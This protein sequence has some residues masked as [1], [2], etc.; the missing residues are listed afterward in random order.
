MKKGELKS[1]RGFTVIEVALVL[2]IA[3]L[4]FLMV[5]VALPGLRTSQR[6]TERREDV[7]N[8]LSNLKKYQTNNRG[9]L[10]TKDNGGREEYSYNSS[11]AGT[12]VTWEYFYRD[13]LGE[14]FMDPNGVN[15]TLVVKKCSAMAANRDCENVNLSNSLFPNDYKIY[16]VT[17]AT[18]SGEKAVGTSNPRKVAVLYKLEGAGVYCNNT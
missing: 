4:I 1:R 12:G 2:A 10:P 16:V 15:Y 13:Y 5:F 7:M 17:K 6:D 9:A 11:L 3:G 14:N 18:C 8:F